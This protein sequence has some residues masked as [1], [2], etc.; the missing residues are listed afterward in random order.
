MTEFSSRQYN[1]MYI[2]VFT[3]VFTVHLFTV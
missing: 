1:C 2:L 3:N